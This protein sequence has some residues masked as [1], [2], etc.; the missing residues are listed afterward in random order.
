MKCFSYWNK[1]RAFRGGDL[2]MSVEVQVPTD[3]LRQN[4]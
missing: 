2:F 3:T 4:L 1:E